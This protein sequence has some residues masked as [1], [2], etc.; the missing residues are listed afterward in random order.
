MS[1]LVKSLFILIFVLSI[2]SAHS[3]NNPKRE[4]RAVWIATVLNIDWP[5]KSGLSVKM[6]KK[7]IDELLDFYHTLNMNTIILQVRPSAD[8][9]YMSSY[10]PWSRFLNGQ[11]GEAPD[12]LYDPLHY[13]IEACHNRGMELHA[14]FNPFRVKNTT[15][16]KLHQGHIFNRNPEWGWQ[17]GSKYYMDPGVPDVREYVTRVVMDVVKH[18]DIDGVHFDDYFYP[19]P[20]PGKVIPDQKT[21]L[22]YGEGY[23]SSNIEDWRRENINRF[24]STLGEKIKAEKPWVKF[25]I[26]PFGV[27][28]NKSSHPEGSLTQAGVETYDDLF[29]DVLKWMKEGWIDYLVPQLYW[30]FGHTKADFKTLTDWWDNHTYGRAVYVG[31]ALYRLSDP[32]SEPAWKKPGELPSQIR[33]VR[34]SKNIK[35]SA[36]FSSSQFY[37][38]PLGFRDSLKNNYYKYPALVPVMNWIDNEPTMPPVNLRGVRERDGFLHIRW[39]KPFV[40]GELNMPRFYVL[41]RCDEGDKIDPSNPKYIHT[42]TN[43]NEFLI[44]VPFLRFK[45][46]TYI[47]KVTTLDRLNNESEF[48]NTLIISH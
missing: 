6:Q 35:G 46:E 17:Y 7:E 8:A 28:R 1:K 47:Y 37:K 10:E 42:I 15:S 11:Q 19:Y 34:N 25:G 16:E 18:Y 5:S 9:F 4:F 33:Y 31:H 43:Q 45:K 22:K 48:S 13:F 12:P 30:Q 32:T 40:S 41:Y 2:Q 29:A 21:F 23:T 20:L 39:D 38:E 24:I 26:S 3:Q 36:W 44:K 14:W 27:W